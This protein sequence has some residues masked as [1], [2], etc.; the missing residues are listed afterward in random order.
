MTWKRQSR[1]SAKIAIAAKYSKYLYPYLGTELSLF[2]LLIVASVTSLVSPYILKVIIDDVF[3]HRAYIQ[4]VEILLV[5]LASYVV[6]IGC[7][8]ILERTYAIV[9]LRIIRDIRTDIFRNLVAKPID[10]Y[11]GNQSA[12][13][14]FSV[15]NDVQ[16]I[17]GAIS[18]LIL[19][20]VIDFLTVT[21]ILIMLSVINVKLTLLSILLLPL[22]L[23]TIAKF[24]PLLHRALMRFQEIQ[25][26]T[27]SI[28]YELVRNFRVIR[29]YHTVE[30]EASKLREAQEKA[31]SIGARRALLNALNS[32]L[33]IF[34]MASGPI[35]V[36]SFAAKDIFNGLMTI[37]S[38]VAFLQYLN[39]IYTPTI[40]MMNCYNNFNKAFVSMERLEKY[41]P[42]RDKIESVDGQRLL[43]LESIRFCNVSLSFGGQVVFDQINLRFERG[44]IYGIVGPS[45]SGKTSIVNLLCGL[46]TPTSGVLVINDTIDLEEIRNWPNFLSLVEKENQ[47]FAGSIEDNIRYGNFTAGAEVIDQACDRAMLKGVAALWPDGLK[48]IVT[49][50]GGFLSDGQKQRISIARGLIKT[51]SV[52]I[53]DE[54]TAAIDIETEAA[55]LGN[56]RRL[57]GSCITI[58]ITHRSSC[59]SF[60]DS[61]YH[62]DNGKIAAVIQ[63]KDVESRHSSMV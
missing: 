27:N 41:L 57:Y 5:L 15:M 40:S 10:F 14:V 21:G 49:E 25:Q 59:L 9:S 38:L 45:G 1:L 61:I 53:F 47:L 3:P 54:A 13:I 34:M 18:S 33:S 24:M 48:T 50:N 22:I 28:F 37:G 12:D 58:I 63:P 7:G 8:I 23:F 56:I 43:S 46:L 32:N 29:S 4:L 51:N 20:F 6:R 16:N 36:L 52:I 17:E 44:K 2:G 55:I 35:L 11:R 42:D 60:F 30:F 62:V 19:N 39:K 26:Q 31:V